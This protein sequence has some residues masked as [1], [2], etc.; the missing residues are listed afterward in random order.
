[1][2]FAALC[3]DAVSDP[4]R[5]LQSKPSTAER[6]L[7]PLGLKTLLIRESVIAAPQALRHRTES[8]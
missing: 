4:E 2:V 1:M 7:A 6:I 5:L 8:L 3:G